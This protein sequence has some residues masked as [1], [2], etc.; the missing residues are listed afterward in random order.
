MSKVSDAAVDDKALRAERQSYTRDGEK[1]PGFTSSIVPTLEEKTIIE[2]RPPKEQVDG[3]LP[4]TYRSETV[5]S[6]GPP[7]ARVHD[8]SHEL[9]GA[10]A[11]SV[12]QADNEVP[13][14]RDAKSDPALDTT[15]E[16]KAALHARRTV[17]K[18]L[19]AGI[20]SQWALPTPTP[21][22]DPHGFEDPVCDA[23]WKNTWVACAVHNVCDFHFLFL[24]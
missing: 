13:H 18:H 23:F 1:E 21:H 2:Q 24:I 12:P 9:Y 3:E 22:V 6:G 11:N 5:E 17:R 20:T 8:G 7:E 14:A 19:E 10:P 4:P 16:E 15:D